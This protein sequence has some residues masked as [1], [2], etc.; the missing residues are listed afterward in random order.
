MKEVPPKYIKEIRPPF[1][2]KV[3]TEVPFMEQPHFNWSGYV[4]L[5]TLLQHSGFSVTPDHLFHQSHP[6]EADVTQL[7]NSA[8]RNLP[9]PTYT[10]L[11][12]MAKDIVGE[13]HIV[14]LFHNGTYKNKI[15]GK[16]AREG[17]YDSYKKLSP[18]VT[19]FHLLDTLL[20][21]D[22]PAMVRIRARNV[23][24]VGLGTQDN[25]A[26]YKVFNPTKKEPEIISRETLD[27]LWKE[28]DKTQTLPKKRFFLPKYPVMSTEYLMLAIYPKKART[29]KKES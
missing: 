23:V 8:I 25:Q 28:D 26:A 11:A 2:G 4:G 22:T 1:V 15:T 9:V 29:A 14:R 20:H 27:A 10:H 6:Q 5:S 24:I 12:A 19:P 3:I 16:Y 17:T 13:T 21:R 7:S 18:S